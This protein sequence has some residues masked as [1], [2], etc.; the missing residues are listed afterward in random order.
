MPEC[1]TKASG[2]RQDPRVFLFPLWMLPREAKEGG[3]PDTLRDAEGVLC[4]PRG[5]FE[6]GFGVREREEPGLKL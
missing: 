2:F 3:F 5:G 4:D 6:V 1:P